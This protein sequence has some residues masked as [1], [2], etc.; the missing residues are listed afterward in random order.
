VER[1]ER[2]FQRVKTGTNILTIFMRWKAHATLWIRA[3]AIA[4]MALMEADTSSSVESVRRGL[5]L[6]RFFISSRRFR[7]GL[8]GCG[9]S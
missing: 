2:A 7:A 6:P 5:P 4:G 3:H 9:R 1:T 8:D